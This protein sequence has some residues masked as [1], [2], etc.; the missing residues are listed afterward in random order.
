MTDVDEQAQRGSSLESLKSSLS[1]IKDS[2]NKT[3]Q[4]F[5]FL[6]DCFNTKVPEWAEPESQ[7]LEAELKEMNHENR[8]PEEE[9]VLPL[10][11][12]DHL[13]RYEGRRSLSRTAANIDILTMLAQ[14]ELELK[15]VTQKSQEMGLVLEESFGKNKILK[16][17]VCQLHDKLELLL[18]TQ[19]EEDQARADLMLQKEV[20]LDQLREKCASLEERYNQ[21]LVQRETRWQM[22]MDNEKSLLEQIWLMK[23]D[24]WKE[25]MSHTDEELK[26]LITELDQ[27]Q[28][29][30]AAKDGLQPKTEEKEEPQLLELDLK[31]PKSNRRRRRVRKT[32]QA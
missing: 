30:V 1:P 22:K 15:Q 25:H 4:E 9:E 7:D 32:E 21:D 5:Q 8:A 26:T 24:Q 12:L 27:L 10:K 6:Q 20:E 29:L 3:L 23:E 28:K 13:Q 18:K 14:K 11:A 17:E 31:N 2:V 19:Q 16:E